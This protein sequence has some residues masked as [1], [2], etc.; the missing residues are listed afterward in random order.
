MFKSY[1]GQKK[2]FFWAILFLKTKILFLKTKFLFLKTK[3]LPCSVLIIVVLCCIIPVLHLEEES[4]EVEDT[5]HFSFWERHLISKATFDVNPE[6]LRDPATKQ[7]ASRGLTDEKVKA[8]Y[9]H[10]KS[11]GFYRTHPLVCVT[12]SDQE[13]RGRRVDLED[14]Q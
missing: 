11:K 3:A 6:H 9:D 7:L 14:R 8:M 4:S 5:Q 13:L 2:N 12:F 10:I 1:C